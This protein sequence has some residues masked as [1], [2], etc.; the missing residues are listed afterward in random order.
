MC[1]GRRSDIARADVV[2]V[3]RCRDGDQ[4]KFACLGVSHRRVPFIALSGK[5]F[6]EWVGS[7]V[8]RETLPLDPVRTV[9]RNYLAA[10]ISRSSTSKMSVAPGLIV[11]GAPLSP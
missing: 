4:D 10:R 2:Y 6:T 7:K 3:M 8:E 9:V 11:G 5:F 1:D